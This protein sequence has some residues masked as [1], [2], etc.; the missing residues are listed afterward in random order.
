MGDGAQY[1]GYD[2]LSQ[3]C[4]SRRHPPPSMMLAEDPGLAVP[5]KQNHFVVIFAVAHFHARRTYRHAR[6]AQAGGV[7]CFC[8]QAPDVPGRYVAFN[9]VTVDKGC[10]TAAQ[11]GNQARFCLDAAHVVAVGGGHLEPVVFQMVDPVGAATAGWRFVHMDALGGGAGEGRRSKP[12]CCHQA[13]SKGMFFHD[14]YLRGAGWSFSCPAWTARTTRLW[15]PSGPD[16]KSTRLNSSHVR[17]SYA[18]FCLK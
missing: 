18:V 2:K 15:R 5:L 11:A 16:R 10:V 3:I 13:K 4:K 8:Q 12:E 1:N 17:I 9:H 14:I 6:H 7:G